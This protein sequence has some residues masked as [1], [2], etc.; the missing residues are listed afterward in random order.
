MLA[1]I[2]GRFVV[3]DHVSEVEAFASF[4]AHS[5]RDM[6]STHSTRPMR[7]LRRRRAST[8]RASSSS[9]C[10]RLRAR[11]DRLSGLARGCGSRSEGSQAR[12]SSARASS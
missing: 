7:W 8:T 5:F 2:G 6:H 11:P 3:L 10:W 12:G 4:T 1:A 9:C